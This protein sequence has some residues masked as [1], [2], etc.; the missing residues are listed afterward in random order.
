M[1]NFYFSFFSS[2]VAKGT[3]NGMNSPRTSY[4]IGLFSVLLSGLVIF[5]AYRCAMNAFLSVRI[6]KV[7]IK[8][9]D[10]VYNQ[11]YSIVMWK[12]GVLEHFVQ[13]APESSTFSRVYR[14]A[15][16]TSDQD[17]YMKGTIDGITRLA[18]EKIVM[19]DYLESVSDLS[20]FYP[21]QVC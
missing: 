14:R 17:I 20:E 18:S 10:D 2:M 13:S 1:H 11:G 9:M 3:P 19:F 6:T 21:C 7:P 15:L 4:R 12:N 16:D 5:T 8:S